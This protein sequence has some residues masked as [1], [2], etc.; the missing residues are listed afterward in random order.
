MTLLIPQIILL[1]EIYGGRKRN[2]S[3]TID[4][5][6]KKLKER[7]LIEGKDNLSY[8]CTELGNETV[9]MIIEQTEEE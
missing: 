5:D 3:P 7:G 2:S 1:L 9:K 4:H 8:S 6:M